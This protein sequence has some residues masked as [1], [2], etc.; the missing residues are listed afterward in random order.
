MDLNSSSKSNFNVAHIKLCT[1]TEGPFKRCCIW[2]QGCDLKCPGCCNE[3]LQPLIPNHIM[4]LDELMGVI[5][6]ARADF[7]IEGITLSGGEPLLQKGLP[8]LLKAVHEAGLGTI[9]FT[10][11]YLSSVDPTVLRHV[12][13]LI[14]GPFL[15]DNRDSSRVLLGSTNKGLHFLTDRYKQQESYFNNPVAIEEI[16]LGPE[17]FFINGD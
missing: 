10:G 11:R 17:Y 12:D 4:G 9:V 15:E 14:D 16:A 3:S 7:G 6:Q 5:L 13:L 2:F 1:R 8:L